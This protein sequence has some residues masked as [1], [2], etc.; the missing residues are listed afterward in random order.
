ML[1][2][3]LFWIYLVSPISSFNIYVK[4]SLIFAHVPKL[5]ELIY[6]IGFILMPNLYFVKVYI[7]GEKIIFSC[8]G[9]S[10]IRIVE[11]V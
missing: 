6:K 7:M 3:I 4:F 9:N 10:P 8:F 2:A 1:G 5:H 11:L